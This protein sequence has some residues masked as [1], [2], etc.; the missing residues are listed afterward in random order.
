[1]SMNVRLRL[2]LSLHAEA[3]SSMLG[4]L[5]VG[6]AKHI[7]CTLSCFAAPCLHKTSQAHWRKHAQ[8]VTLAAS[9][10][11]SLPPRTGSCRIP[12]DAAAAAAFMCKADG[13]V[14]GLAVA[15]AIFAACD[16]A[17]EVKWQCK[18]GDAV[19]RSQQLGTVSGSARAILLAERIALNFMQ[20]RTLSMRC[21][22]GGRQADWRALTVVRR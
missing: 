19:H 9:C 15:D 17:I 2:R 14:A 1:M 12:A 13:I 10:N 11:L 3:D 7:G 16:P 20:V 8:H 4:N 21:S 6:T 22:D 18:D 5:L